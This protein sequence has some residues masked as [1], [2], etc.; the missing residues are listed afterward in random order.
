MCRLDILQPENRVAYYF[1]NT[2]EVKGYTLEGHPKYLE[3]TQHTHTMQHASQLTEQK[4][5]EENRCMPHPVSQMH[6]VYIQQLCKMFVTYHIVP[7]YP[8]Q[9]N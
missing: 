6:S 4:Q 8:S 7:W 9:D 1:S 3:L 5:F 2:K